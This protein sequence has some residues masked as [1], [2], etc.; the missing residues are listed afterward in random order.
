MKIYDT[1]PPISSQLVV[2]E[3]DPAIGLTH[4]SHLGH[5]DTTTVTALRM[6]AHTGAHVDAPCHSPM[7]F[8][9]CRCLWWAATGPR[10]ALFSSNLTNGVKP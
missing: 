8:I 3:G 7:N 4:V 10:R 5:D 6:G 9:V 2:W 1:T